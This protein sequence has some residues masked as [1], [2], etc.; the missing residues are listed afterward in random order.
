[1]LS[2]MKSGVR[3]KLKK[4]GCRARAF[5]TP[6]MNLI[7]SFGKKEKQMVCIGKQASLVVAKPF[8]C[9]WFTKLGKIRVCMRHVHQKLDCA[10]SRKRHTKKPRQIVKGVS[11]W[12]HGLIKCKSES[13]FECRNVFQFGNMLDPMVVHVCVCVC[14]TEHIVL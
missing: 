8:L 13:S 6:H 1:M 2:P 7:D 12:V 10:F 5:T 4:F 11:W 14:N 9:S 3:E